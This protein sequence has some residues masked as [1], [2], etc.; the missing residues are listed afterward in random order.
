MIIS[1]NIAHD[2]R[3]ASSSGKVKFLEDYR[4]Y[5]MDLDN[6]CEVTY[7]S[8]PGVGFGNVAADIGQNI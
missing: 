5:F 1:D 8:R 6:I 3:Y 2:I 7:M 4:W